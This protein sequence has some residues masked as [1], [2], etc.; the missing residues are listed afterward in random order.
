MLLSD[1]TSRFLICLL[2]A[3]VLSVDAFSDMAVTAS[4]DDGRME[5]TVLIERGTF[6]P[7]E[8]AIPRA[9]LRIVSDDPIRFPEGNHWFADLHL[10]TPNG[11][12]VICRFG[13]PLGIDAKPA[14]EWYK[15]L[16]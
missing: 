1:G 9:T 16:P 8:T 6:A 7:G 4:G 12:E 10:R 15:H 5:V 13:R 11:T 2:L 14:N 3:T